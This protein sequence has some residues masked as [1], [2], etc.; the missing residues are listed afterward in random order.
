MN[1]LLP[2]YQKKSTFP[3]LVRNA[4][5][6]L[7]H[8]TCGK[9]IYDAGG[10]GMLSFGHNHPE[11][12]KALTLPQCMANVMTP[13]ETIHRAVQAL[14]EAILKNPYSKYVFLNSGSEATA[15]ALRVACSTRDPRPVS[16]IALKGGFHG[17]MDI[18]TRVSESIDMIYR[19]HVPYMLHGVR[20]NYVH[21]NDSEAMKKTFATEE[22]LGY[23]VTAFIAEPVMGE[24][25]TG[26]KLTSKYL[27]DVQIECRRR[28]T[29]MIIDSVQ[30]GLRCTGELSVANYPG[31]KNLKPDM[32]I[33][34]KAIHGGQ[35]PVS[36]L[37]LGPRAVDKFVT[38]T[39][40]NT[41]TGNPR[42]LAVVHSVLK[43]MTPE[44]KHNIRTQGR[45]LLEDLKSLSKE[46]PGVI[47]QVNGQGLLLGIK[48]HNK[49]NATDFQRECRIRGL[50]L[51]EAA[52]NTIRLTPT[53][54]IDDNGRKIIIL[55]LKETCAHAQQSNQN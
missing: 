10:Y 26:L 45:A 40:G 52:G 43:L 5:G 1:R 55:V 31:V 9:K 15:L 22:Q 12:L 47:R 19:T 21:P 49:H 17:R 50:N 37:A 20:V 54:T 39:Y 25:N 35:F 41:M 6:S 13:N 28:E 44:I 14:D 38:G 53:F 34:S 18:A 42:A 48:L 36:I 23:N 46:Y 32:E 27:H 24:G 8:T 30:A 16:F 2:L 11:I 3:F 29:S 51:I 33:F 4:S 7:I